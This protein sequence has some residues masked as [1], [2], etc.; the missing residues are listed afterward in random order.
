MGPKSYCEGKVTTGT[1]H[2]SSI[3]QLDSLVSFISP[4]LTTAIYNIRRC[5]RYCDIM[6]G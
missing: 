5:N 3:P 4:G 2:E 6:G 1:R